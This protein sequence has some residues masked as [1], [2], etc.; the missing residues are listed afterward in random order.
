MAELESANV[1]RT[2]VCQNVTSDAVS[3][4]PLN[5][6]VRIRSMDAS[7]SVRDGVGS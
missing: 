6:F 4:C 7:E 5:T 3:S 1:G 2:V